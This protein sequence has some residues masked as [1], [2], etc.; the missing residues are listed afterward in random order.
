MKYYLV[1]L[2]M[3]LLFSCKQEVEETK[4]ISNS[5]FSS[6]YEESNDEIKLV[7]ASYKYSSAESNG[8]KNDI[9]LKVF[10]E[11]TINKKSKEKKSIYRI[12]PINASWKI[13]V[14][15]NSF[16][17]KNNTLIAKT[18]AIDD[19][20]DTYSIY[21]L[22][23]GNHLIDYTYDK[24]TVR[25]PDTNFKR[26]IGYSS[27]ANSKNLLKTYGKDAI[28]LITYATEKNEIQKILIKSK[29]KI[30]SIT[31]DMSLISLSE[32]SRLFENGGA[33]YFMDYDE[34]Y[35]KE[36]IDFAFEIVYYVGENADESSLYFEIV[37]D[38]ILKDKLKYNK[39][40]FEIEFL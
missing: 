24:L 38:E 1:P 20:E 2:F 3:I 37:D 13:N 34:N 9:I 23:T 32:K 4:T 14:E 27:L 29:E 8:T 21:N 10:Q 17:I 5:D 18:D 33:L 35:K 30:D 15:A 22:E 12:E 36:D 40:I 16:D 26:F 6:K 7:N 39:D 19:I 11:E 31:P 25:I 28:G